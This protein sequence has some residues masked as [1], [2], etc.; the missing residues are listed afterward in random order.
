M[1]IFRTKR[2]TKRMRDIRLDRLSLSSDNDVSHDSGYVSLIPRRNSRNT[3]PDSSARK[4]AASNTDAEQ[5]RLR[6]HQHNE[7]GLP[8]AQI[9]DVSDTTRN[10]SETTSE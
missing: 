6:Y 8:K 3:S 2:Y 7:S 10:S 1:N 9:A 4:L 5:W